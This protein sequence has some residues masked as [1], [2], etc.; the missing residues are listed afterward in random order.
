MPIVHYNT[1]SNVDK[2]ADK[3]TLS[4]EQFETIAKETETK[5]ANDYA[6]YK[7]RL[8]A[9]ASLG[10]LY[11]G[12]I[13]VILLG[14]VL[15]TCWL[16]FAGHRIYAGAIKIVIVL[17]ILV[18]LV[19]KSLWIKYDPPQGIPL[20]RQ[21][22]P[23]LFKL[24]DEICVKLN[25][26]AD[27]VV[28]D[29]TFN[30]A[31]TEHPK[32]GLLGFNTN[33]LILG[34]PFLQSV[35]KE[36]LKAVL[37]HEFGHLSGKH[38]QTSRWIYSLRIQWANILEKLGDK[39]FLF[40]PFFMWY[41]P[42]YVAYSMILIRDHEKAADADSVK[43]T[44]ADAVGNMLMLVALK[45]KHLGEEIWQEIYK[46][47]MT[48]EEAPEGI[49]N[50]IGERIN[51]LPVRKLR[52]WLDEELKAEGSKI[53]THPPTKERLALCGQLSKFENISDEDLEKLVAPIPPGESAAEALLG[54]KLPQLSA[55]ISANWHNQVRELW[56]Q[57]HQYYLQVKEEINKLEVKQEQEPLTINDLKQK[58]YLLEELDENKEAVP[59][60]YQIL[61]QNPSDAIA[62][63]NLGAY[64]SRKYKQ[65]NLN[66]DEALNL[67]EQSFKTDIR[68]ADAAKYLAC[69]YL[70]E[71]KRHHESERFEKY[72]GEIK[73]AMDERASLK[74]TDEFLQ[75]DLDKETMQ[76]VVEMCQAIPQ[77]TEMCVVKKNV[78]KYPASRHF[79][80]GAK[81]YAKGVD[82][83]EFRLSM[84]NII[85][86]Y[87]NQFP[88]T[89]SVV[90]FD[91]WT[92]KL[93]QK[94]KDVPGSVVFK[95]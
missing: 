65:E 48:Q 38:S 36:E 95:R 19:L 70:R 24:L 17:L 74:D 23:E 52:Q 76:L 88:G 7:R 71:Q 89:K 39:S 18:F 45:G 37:A 93:E 59:I 21:D 5:A 30:A 87:F 11:I 54:D 6:G 67:L 35:R 26:R 12:F 63:F 62:D 84:A 44:G 1:K 68:L 13:V 82:G 83:E 91:M 46:K 22:Y 53:E 31:V 28:L 69:N 66:G 50:E 58:A 64:I 75:E 47:A 79:V 61:E 73:E 15:I 25:T 60:Y 85:M 72:E 77:I 20:G 3:L 32:L 51:H 2:L 29:E 4:D 9:F 94:M 92:K 16:S 10:Y 49:Y 86:Q 78:K 80:I 56:Q 14:L 57:R 55:Q 34:L 40:Y 43:I 90:V 41:M 42:R 81:V 33:Y 27:K 8:I